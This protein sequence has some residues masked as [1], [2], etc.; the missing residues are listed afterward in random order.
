MLDRYKIPGA[1][2]AI[3]HQGELVW[4]GNFGSS[5]LENQVPIHQDTV[6]Q[7]A[8]ISKLVASLGVMHLVEQGILDLDEPVGTYLTRWQLPTSDYNP[9]EVTLRRILSHTAGLS[10]SGYPGYHPD[11]PLPSLEES[12][13]GYGVPAI[14]VE[15]IQPPGHAF[16]YSGGGYTLVELIIE[17]VTGIS[18]TDFMDTEI[19]GPMGMQNSSFFWQQHLQ[20]NTAKAYDDNLNLLPNF[21]Y[22]EKAAAGLYTTAQ[23]LALLAVNQHN[24][25]H[26][27]GLFSKSSMEE[28]IQPVTGITGIMSLIYN[29]MGLGHFIEIT[30]DGKTV[31]SHDGSNQ[32]WRSSYTLV[33]ETGDGL[34]VLTNGNNGTYLYTEIQ[35]AW[36]E[37]IF[38]SPNTLTKNLRLINRIGYSL[39]AVLML[40]TLAAFINIILDV[41]A[42]S[43]RFTIKGGKWHLAIRILVVVLLG[44]T[45]LAVNTVLAPMT[46][47]IVPLLGIVLASAVTNRALVGMLQ[48]AI[49][50]VKDD[51][52]AFAN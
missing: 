52:L 9:Q 2:I 15:L 38:Q 20:A 42:G 30:E 14:P 50:K 41:K 39:S 8:S 18:F 16:R 43:R 37:A 5:D 25:Y 34:V 36:H 6:F 12:L 51:K 26:S 35:G 19:L 1:A 13:S 24:S 45:V 32:G 47:Q 17:E 29:D 22:A 49:P 21:L 3:V 31:V 10:L 48:M 23:D 44:L 11:E 40:W 4:S 46:A 7:V 28:F 33:P 27:Q